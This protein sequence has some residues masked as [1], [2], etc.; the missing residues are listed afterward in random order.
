MNLFENEIKSEAEHKFDKFDA[1]NPR[2]YELFKRF[3]LSAIQKGRNRIGARLIIERIRWETMVETTD[4]D[5][6]I[7][8]NYAP[9][10]VRKFIKDFPEYSD[11][12]QI[13]QLRNG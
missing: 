5:Y 10:F 4:E 12:F 11:R 6:K 9:Y 3:A 1:E 7:N 8:N 2:V 13:R